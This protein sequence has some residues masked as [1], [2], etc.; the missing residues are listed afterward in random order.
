MTKDVHFDNFAD[1]IVHFDTKTAPLLYVDPVTVSLTF[2]VAS[3]LDPMYSLTRYARF[4]ILP[5]SVHK[6]VRTSNVEFSGNLFEGTSAGR[7][8][9]IQESEKLYANRAA[10]IRSSQS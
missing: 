5:A 2:E 10:S 1:F 3:K 9:A 8:P 4:A 7:K 6:N